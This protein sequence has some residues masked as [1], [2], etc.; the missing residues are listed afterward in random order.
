MVHS[1][2]PRVVAVVLNWCREADTRACLESLLDGDYPALEILLVDNA[3]PDDSGQRLH[4]AFPHLPYIQTGENLGYTGGNNVGIRW[5]LEAGADYILILNNDTVVDPDTVSRLVTTARQRVDLGAV[6]PLIVY[7]SEP[8]RVW[9]GGGE[10]SRRRALG[11]HE[12]EGAAV[13]GE[14]VPREVRFVTGCCFLSPAAVLDEL[15]GFREDYFAYLEDAELSLRMQEAGY[16]LWYEPRARVRHRIS[17]ERGTETPFQIRQRDR[18]R[19][20]LVREH[21]APVDRLFFAVFFYPTRMIHLF[22]YLV[23]GDL[24]RAGAIVRGMTEP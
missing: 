22:R 9:Y 13:A 18:N 17:P 7:H 21:Y 11:I 14:M 16:T 4:G 2:D 3:S 6:A 1:A 20:R 24:R 12:G 10:F 15:N 8:D 23:K 5:A 19:R